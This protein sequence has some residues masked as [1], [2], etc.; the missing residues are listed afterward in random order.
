M[1]ALVDS[2]SY[3]PAI[4]EVIQ[5]QLQLPV[6]EKRKALL[7]NGHVVECDVVSPI[8][9]RFKNRRSSGTALVLPGQAEPWLGA[10]PSKTWM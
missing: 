5:A 6:V 1:N 8:E 2:G 4:N 9:I 10:I 7:A 3:M